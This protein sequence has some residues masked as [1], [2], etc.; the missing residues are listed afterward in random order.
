MK[1]LWTTHFL[2][3]ATSMCAG[4]P[5]RRCTPDRPPVDAGLPPDAAVVDAGAPDSSAE[6]GAEEAGSGGLTREQ[7][8]D[9]LSCQGCHPKHYEEWSGSMHAYA[10]NDPVFLAMNKRGQRETNGELGKFCVNCHAPMAVRTGAT[11]DGLNLESLPQKL[12]GVTC[13]FCHSVEGVEA[14]H[15]ANNPLILADDGVMRG[16]F[17][18]A[19]PSA[20]HRTGYS[21]M[22]DRNRL[23]SATMCG[24]CH[25]I[26]NGHG[27]HIE[28][29]FDE[30]KKSVFSQAAVG[31]TC[32]QCHMDQ[33]TTPERVAEVPGA[34]LRRNHNHLF[35][36]V[37]VATEPFPNAATAQKLRDANQALL[38]TTLQSA[39]CVR[40][41]PD[42]ANLFVVLDNVAS[43]HAFPSGAAQ[44]R[45]LWVE[46]QAYLRGQ[47]IYSSGVLEN[48]LQPVTE[49]VPLDPDLWLMRDRMFDAEGHE[50]HDFW[51]STC[52]ETQ[53]LPAQLTF[54]QTDPR[55]YQS[56]VTRRYP[57]GN[58]AYLPAFPDRV[59]MRVRLSPIGQDVIQDLIASGDLTQLSAR[60][61]A[62]IYDVGIPSVLEWT[63][64]TAT[65]NYYD[66]TPVP[67]SCISR[68]NLSGAADKVLARPVSNCP[69][70]SAG[71]A[72][73]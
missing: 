64:A 26:V 3:L 25:D 55:F 6:G 37:D 67:V 36:G 39:L 65:E 22:L 45:R 60:D 56:H 18:D 33:S 43:G 28:R 24:V 49:L 71:A 12:K 11:T 9:P 66:Q 42:R 68:T 46:V 73:P 19:L 31:T 32:G 38:N 15:E 41:F 59:T 47:R 50:V 44:D 4:V 8:L 54:S 5:Q 51:A 48:P 72:S 2:A 62:P 20:P 23:E 7:L 1:L 69:A 21:P 58:A 40:G 57:S 14:G 34:P 17:A 63:A 35:P 61:N 27:T 10:A 53:L 52:Y 30:W 16:S 13:Y 70:P 29:T